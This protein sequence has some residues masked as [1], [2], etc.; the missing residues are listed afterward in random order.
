[1]DSTLHAW[2]A[3]LFE[4][5]GYILI[6]RSGVNE[7][8]RC[9]IEMTDKDCIESFAAAFPGGGSIYKRVRKNSNHKPTYTYNINKKAEVRNFLITVLP[10]LHNR[11]AHKALDILD[12]IEC[13]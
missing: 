8:Y 13:N 11:R 4:G 2:A 9:G 10:Y 1:M 3:G 7:K 6:D 12:Y 5:E